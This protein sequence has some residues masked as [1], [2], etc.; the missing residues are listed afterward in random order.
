ML[1]YEELNSHPHLGRRGGGERLRVRGVAA[2]TGDPGGGSC[3]Q[4]STSEA[5]PGKML[6]GP[7]GVE[8]KG[9]SSPVLLA[10]SESHHLGLRGN[11]IRIY[12]HWLGET[13]AGFP[14]DTVLRHVHRRFPCSFP[15]GLM[16]IELSNPNVN[17][18]HRVHGTSVPQI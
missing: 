5:H 11:V 8:A 2:A 18:V 16:E 4:G 17:R 15:P 10:G 14:G 6:W 13:G 1:R 9:L 12:T 7:L 3:A